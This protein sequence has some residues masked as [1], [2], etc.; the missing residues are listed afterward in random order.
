MMT[1]E[2]IIIG[3]GPI[4]LE[5]AACLKC[6]GADYLHFDAK[7]IGYTMSWWPRDTQF[8]STPERIEIVGIPM[9]HTHQ[10]NV[11]GEDGRQHKANAD[12]L[13]HC[14][15]L[16]LPLDVEDSGSTTMGERQEDQ[17]PALPP[18]STAAA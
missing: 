2:T 1:T 17:A 4:G 6:S 10:R 5:V 13:N 18:G 15:N 16:D 7:Q 14:T 12:P 3:A 11:T 9:Q 8:F